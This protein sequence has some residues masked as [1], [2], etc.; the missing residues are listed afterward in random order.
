MSAND[1]T[2]EELLALDHNDHAGAFLGYLHGSRH[3]T[4]K[5]AFLR[6]WVKPD[7]GDLILECGSSSGKTSIDFAR[8][9]QCFCLGVDFDPEAV[10]ISISNRDAHFPE[11]SGRC[12]FERGDLTTMQ[13][14]KPF[15]KIL[16]P[17]FSEHIPD[18]IFAAILDNI[19][20]QLQ[21][22]TLYV[23][24]PNRSHIF[25][26][27]KHKNVVLKNEGGHINV[28]TRKELEGFLAVN[29]WKVESSAWRRS[30]IPIIK[31]FESILGYLPF[32]GRLFQRRIVVTAKPTQ[33]ALLAD[34]IAPGSRQEIKTGAPPRQVKRQMS[35][36]T[37]GRAT[38]TTTRPVKKS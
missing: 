33:A 29:G 27:L 3:S 25:E 4:D 31:H 21:N 35:P 1:L 14:D 20:K 17:D 12:E 10:R 2:D 7:M 34:I 22:A 16:M 18:R 15:N 36:D 30:A 26:I 24:T 19:R 38:A 11:L 9:S 23:Y 32:I 37:V 6:S 5:Q 8:H 13:F 28:K